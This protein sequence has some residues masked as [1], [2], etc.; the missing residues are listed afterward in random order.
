MPEMSHSSQMT[1][2]SGYRGVLVGLALATVLSL[3]SILVLGFGMT[4]TAGNSVLTGVLLAGSLLSTGLVCF[5]GRISLVAADYLFLAFVATIVLSFLLNGG[6]VKAKE[7]LLL[8]VSL[9][10]YPAGRLV[11]GS[12]LAA[13]KPSF[14]SLTGFIVALGTVATGIA[15]VQQWDDQHGKPIVFG[16]DASDAAPG[17]FL[18]SLSLVILAAATMINLTARRTALISV[19]IFLPIAVYAAS[20]VRFAFIALAGGLFVALVFSDARQRRHV[21]TIGVV[22]FLAIA[23]GLGARYAKARIFADFAIEK[24]RGV[25]SWQRPPSCDLVIN[26]NNSIAIRKAL[27]LDAFYLIPRAGPVGTGLDSFMDFS[28]IKN[29]EVHNSFLQAGVEFGWVGGILMALA[30]IVAWRSV[31]PLAW[32]GG[33]PLFVLCSLTF[34][35]LIS[36]AHGRLSRELTVFL[37]LGIAGGVAESTR[38]PSPER[39]G[40]R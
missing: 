39:Q 24:T 37:L 35:I 22:I 10:A 17:N 29:T 33:P 8:A 7:S 40:E 15:L 9:A 28:C 1:Y 30:A 13:I 36:M 5:R 12:D 31:A 34:A 32:Q 16:F 11:T 20:L 25:I 6:S 23:A 2:F 4:G 38:L 26:P 14:L 27:T 18:Q 19:L 21:F 3:S